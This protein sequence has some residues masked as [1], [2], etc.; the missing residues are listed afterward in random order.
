M[1]IHVH[2]LL[3]NT[4]SNTNANV[5]MLES[6]MRLS[7]QESGSNASVGLESSSVTRRLESEQCAA[8]V[9]HERIHERLS[10]NRKPYAPA[11]TTPY[12]SNP[13]MMVAVTNHLEAR[14][15]SAILTTNSDKPN[16]KLSRESHSILEDS[17]PK[18]GK[19][20]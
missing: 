17:P 12:R 7:L 3:S 11:R 16:K 1:T 8:H 5:Y 9:D 10:S 2:V 6:A 14:S 20:K 18:W 19:Q 4:V 15:K 13:W